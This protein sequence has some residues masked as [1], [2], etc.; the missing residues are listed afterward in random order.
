MPAKAKDKMLILFRPQGNSEQSNIDRDYRLI[1][2]WGLA[3][4]VI[5][6]MALFFAVSSISPE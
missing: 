6:L 2:W 4:A 3:L 1:G 5:G